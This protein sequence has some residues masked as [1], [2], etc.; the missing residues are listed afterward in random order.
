MALGK[1]PPVAAGLGY[2]YTTL[3]GPG[4]NGPKKTRNAG[5]YIAVVAP[6]PGTACGSTAVLASSCCVLVITPPLSKLF[7]DAALHTTRVVLRLH[8]DTVSCNGLCA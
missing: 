2:E 6:R 8:D 7:E 3:Y 5:L 1:L 4:F